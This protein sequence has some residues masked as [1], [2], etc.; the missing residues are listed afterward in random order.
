MAYNDAN[1]PFHQNLLTTRVEGGIVND[2]SLKIRFENWFWYNNHNLFEFTVN[3][4]QNCFEEKNK[5]GLRF[6]MILTFVY[7]VY[8]VYSFFVIYPGK[9]INLPISLLY[10]TIW[11]KYLTLGTLIAGCLVKNEE[12]EKLE[13]L[14]YI[15]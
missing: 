2:Q 15:N 13:D 8:N 4:Y 7:A 5:S 9:W 11:G 10:L 3:Q 14:S 6:R 1:D 12:I